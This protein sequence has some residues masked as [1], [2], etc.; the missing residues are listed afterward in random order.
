MSDST[1]D[2]PKVK[3]NATDPTS[4]RIVLFV[5]GHYFASLIASQIVKSLCPQIVAVVFSERITGSLCQ[6]RSVYRKTGLRYFIYRSSIQAISYLQSNVCG[7]SLRKHLA[8]QGVPVLSTSNINT[9]DFG[10]KLPE[11]DLAVTIGF[12]QIIKRDILDRFPKGIV[13]F[14]GSKLP[15]DKGISPLLWAFARGDRE[16][17][18]TI[19]RM[20]EGIDCGE[21][22]DQFSLPVDSR[23]TAI[24]FRK[25]FC[26]LGGQRLYRTVQSIQDGTEPLLGRSGEDEGNYNSWPDVHFTQLLRKHN[27]RLFTLRDLLHL[28]IRN[29]LEQ[30]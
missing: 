10:P 5:N 19:Y 27:R 1:C 21:I 15:H 26:I 12:D 6:I 25:D 16:I 24:S 14:H 11:A 4:L 18:G 30:S 13:N 23:A 8:R 2:R 7:W 29:P 9:R 20:E 17:W 22:L 3:Q 28:L